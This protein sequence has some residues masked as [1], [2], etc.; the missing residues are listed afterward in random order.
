LLYLTGL[1]GKFSNLGNIVLGIGAVAGLAAFVHGS[2]ILAPYNKK[3]IAALATA[4]P[5]GQPANESQ[6][7][8]LNNLVAEY[9]RHARISL[10]LSMIALIG[11][12]LARNL[13]GI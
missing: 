8:A 9:E 5:E 11:M 3:I 13:P 4:L 10:I 1:A 2:A 12:G 6:L 7:A